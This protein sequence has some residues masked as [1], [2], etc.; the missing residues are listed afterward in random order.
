MNLSAFLKNSADKNPE[1]VCLVHNSNRH[2]YAE[3]DRLSD[4]LAVKLV[5]G[6]LREGGRVAIL[7]E[8]SAEYVVSFFGVLKSRGVVV[9]LSTQL[10]GREL[11]CLFSD[12]LP[13][14]VITDFRRR[15][16]LNGLI[17]SEYI[18]LIDKFDFTPSPKLPHSHTAQARDELA[19]IIYTSGT[20]GKPKGVML[21][22]GNL[23]ANADSIVRYLNLRAE[24]SMMVILPFY[25]SYGISLLTTH[26]KVG[27]ALVIDNRFLYPNMILDTMEK[28]GVTGFAG[29]PSNFAILLRKSA[30]SKYRLSKLKYVTQ[31]GGAMAPSMIKEFVELFPHVKFYVMCGQTEASARLTYLEPDLLTKKMVLWVK[32]FLALKLIS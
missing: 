28:E 12:C 29:V 32:R 20:T 13:K 30:L 17:D 27:A 15:A 7:L 25:Y 10:V 1:S 9:P 31:A 24:D 2:T 8:N 21:S 22:H 16:S 23:I 14:F 26:V 19:L 18:I 6:G 4:A 5:E 11:S 3:I